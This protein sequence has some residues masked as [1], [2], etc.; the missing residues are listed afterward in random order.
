MK[1]VSV[2]TAKRR[3]KHEMMIRSWQKMVKKER[4]RVG[5]G[6]EEFRSAP[7]RVTASNPHPSPSTPIPSLPHQTRSLKRRGCPPPWKCIFTG[8]KLSSENPVTRGVTHGSSPTTWKERPIRLG[9]LWTAGECY[10]LPPLPVMSLSFP[11]LLSLTTS[12]SRFLGS[13][14]RVLP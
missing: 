7:H 1:C 11:P 12:F 4:C 3:K 13:C 6:V 9:A 5:V 8:P 14:E 10:S 2:T